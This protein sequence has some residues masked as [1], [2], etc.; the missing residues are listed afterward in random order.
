MTSFLVGFSSKQTL[1]PSGEGCASPA[2]F[3]SSAVSVASSILSDLS[4]GTGGL[5]HF[6]KLNDA[7]IGA[8]GIEERFQSSRIFAFKGSFVFIGEGFFLFRRAGA[9]RNCE[10]DGDED[11]N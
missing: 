1:P 9:K 6:V 8:F 4:A 10:K 2:F 3:A 11:K 7:R 5:H